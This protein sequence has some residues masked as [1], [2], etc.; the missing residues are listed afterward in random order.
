MV[1]QA[2]YLS[3]FNLSPTHKTCLFTDGNKA[4]VSAQTRHASAAAL[5]RTARP[6]LDSFYRLMIDIP[7]TSTDT[8]DTDKSALRA[9][10]MLS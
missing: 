9:Q 6:A 1:V 7:S 10:L 2:L 5:R 4:N 8:I 3:I